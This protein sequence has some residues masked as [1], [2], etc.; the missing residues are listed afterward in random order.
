MR[1]YYYLYST[2]DAGATDN[3]MHFSAGPLE[4]YQLMFD[5]N[6]TSHLVPGGGQTLVPI[7]S[8]IV[9]QASTKTNWGRYDFGNDTVVLVTAGSTTQ[10]LP[11]PTGTDVRN[12]KITFKNDSG[13]TN[14]T[15]NSQGSS[16]TIDGAASKTLAAAYNF[17]TVISNG[18]EWKMVATG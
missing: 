14:T 16:K 4:Y 5:S 8:K 2:Q 17:I 12:M 18:T 10:S 3:N 9:T 15:I 11:D 13:V 6:S 1:G 7:E